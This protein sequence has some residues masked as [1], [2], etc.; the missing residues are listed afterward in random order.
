MT[1]PSTLRRFDKLAAGCAQGRLR[2]PC[3]PHQITQACYFVRDKQDDKVIFWFSV[4]G[5]VGKMSKERLAYSG[6]YLAFVVLGCAGVASE[7]I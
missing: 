7:N 3:S 6:Q 1:S 5:L 4:S 2:R